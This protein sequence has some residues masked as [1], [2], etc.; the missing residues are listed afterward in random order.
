MLRF[1]S[2]FIV[3]VTLMLEPY[4]HYGIYYNLINKEEIVEATKCSETTSVCVKLDY[5]R[6]APSD[7]TIYNTVV[8][9]CLLG[10]STK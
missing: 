7:A 5:I 8:K 10:Y 4:K 9:V 6:L 1:H 2:Y 3:G